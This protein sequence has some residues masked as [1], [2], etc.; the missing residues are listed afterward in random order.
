M[1]GTGNWTQTW[2]PISVIAKNTTVVVVAMIKLIM[3]MMMIMRLWHMCLLTA[4]ILSSS[5][6]GIKGQLLESS[7]RMILSRS[8]YSWHMTEP[9]LSSLANFSFASI[10]KQYNILQPQHY[11]SALSLFIHSFIHTSTSRFRWCNVKMTARTPNNVK[12]KDGI[13]HRTKTVCHVRWM[14]SG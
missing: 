9:S 7:S 5:I 4:G 13:H 12:R 2:S 14:L 11:Q 3:T 10:S 8:R 6:D 1:S